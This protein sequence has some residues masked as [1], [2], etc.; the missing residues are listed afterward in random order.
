MMSFVVVVVVFVDK[1]Y[2][3]FIVLFDLVYNFGDVLM[4]KFLDKL[5]KIV[6]N[7]YV[8]ELDME[9]LIKSY[10]KYLEENF[11]YM[12]CYLIVINFEKYFE[13][14]SFLLGIEEY[15]ML[16]VVKEI[17]MKGDE[18][19][20]IVF[21]IFFMG[22]IFRVFVFL[23]I[24]FIWMDKFIEI[25]WV[26]LERR[27]VI[28]NIY[29]EQEFVVEGEWI[30]FF[31]KE[32]EDFVMKELK[33]YRKEVVFVESVFIDFDK[34]SV[35]VVMN[36]EMFL[37]YE[38]ER[39]YESFKKFRILFNMIVMNKVFELKGEVL[40]LKVKLEVQERVLM[41]VFEKFKGVDIVKIF[42]FFEEF[43]GVE[44]FR[45]FGGVIIGEC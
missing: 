10:L 5:K 27:V 38:I 20:V 39:V 37:L 36:F 40:E 12:Y 23:R 7:F 21:D 35:V 4:E 6:E 45:E 8:S 42:I 14:F 41:E 2:R 24:L 16:E 13:V 43:C 34:M 17:L 1:G 26:I 3:I 19:D 9:K 44:R 28:V 25:W 30:K 18:W 32:E 33:V 29:G 11:K 15:V 31:I 22:L